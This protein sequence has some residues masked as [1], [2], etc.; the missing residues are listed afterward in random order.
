MFLRWSL[1]GS[2][3]P[4]AFRADNG[5]QEGSAGALS[6]T[7]VLFDHPIRAGMADHPDEWT[8]TGLGAVHKG[9][10]APAGGDRDVFPRPVGAH[11]ATERSEPCSEGGSMRTRHFE[12]EERQS[13]RVDTVAPARGGRVETR[14]DRRAL[15]RDAGMGQMSLT[16]ILAGTLAAYGA[17]AVLAIAGGVAAA[18]NNGTDFNNV[19]WTQLK[20]GAGIVVAVVLLVSYLYGGCVAG[21]MARRSTASASSCSAWSW[22]SWSAC[23]SSRRVVAATSR[24][25]CATWAPPQPGTSGA[26][27]ARSPVSPPW[28]PCSSGHSSAARWATVREGGDHGLLEAAAA[29][30]IRPSTPARAG[31]RSTRRPSRRA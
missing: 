13:D 1:S 21:R 20:A 27:S 17:V 5:V 2:A 12:R 24:P 26:T 22:P 9:A 15:A 7:S 28:S 31:R 19:A 3:P 30:A 6:N 4:G 14:K 23:S 29:R 16:S 8:E 11:T 18:I 25:L 10:S